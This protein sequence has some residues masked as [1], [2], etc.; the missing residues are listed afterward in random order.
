MSRT[1]TEAELSQLG[2]FLEEC[3]TAVN[4]ELETRLGEDDQPERLLQAMKYA[5]MA[6]G[7]RLRPSLV[8]LG[9]EAAGGARAKAIP[10]AAAIE[11]IHTYSLIHDDLPC[12]DDDDYRRGRPTVHRQFDEAT[13]V[14]AG[15]AL[16]ALAFEILSECGDIEIIREVARA[17]GTEGI[18]GGQMDDLLAEG[19]APTEKTVSS[20]HLRKTAVLITA[21]VRIGGLLG[22]ASPETMQQLTAYGRDIGL[23]FQI[24]DDILDE[25]GTTEELGKPVGSDREHQKATYPA[26]V[27]MEQARARAEEL[28]ESTKTAI[29]GIPHHESLFVALADYLILRTR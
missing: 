24:I 25:I 23:A 10:A 19:S 4:R 7:K 15:D 1:T 28:T 16:H 3:R 2:T 11:C 26:A 8:I 22:Q 27:G 12:M 5:V 17:I 9:C 13:A 18:L 6:G 29:Y 14:L 21:S 20:I